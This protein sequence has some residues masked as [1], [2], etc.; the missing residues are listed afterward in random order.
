MGFLRQRDSLHSVLL[1]WLDLSHIPLCL[2]LRPLAKIVA[3]QL[4]MLLAFRN[5]VKGVSH[6]KGFGD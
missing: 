2:F 4:H 3:A 5:E 1:S 6:K